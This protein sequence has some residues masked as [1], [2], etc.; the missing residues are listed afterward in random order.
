MTRRRDVVGLEAVLAFLC[1]V[2]AIAGLSSG[3][4]EASSGQEQDITVYG[5]SAA[6]LRD[7]IHTM[8]GPVTD[9]QLARWNDKL[10]ICVFGLKPEFAAILVRTLQSAAESTNLKS[11]VDCN[12]PNVLIAA[13]NGH[14]EI[15]K[16]IIE[17]YPDMPFI[18][19][20]IGMIYQTS[21]GISDHLRQ[22]LTEAK[23]VRWYWSTEMTPN[24][25]SS[26]GFFIQ[27]DHGVVMQPHVDQSDISA[28]RE[29]SHRETHL[30]IVTINTDLA[31]GVSWGALGSYV[32]MVALT[33]PPM[34]AS[35]P[36]YS[37]MSLFE[38]KIASKP[39]RLTEFD[40]RF[41]KAFYASEND[42]SAS[43]QVDEIFRDMT[44][45]RP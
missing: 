4:A 45:G 5:V 40:T 30:A 41:L 12:D 39:D 43:D 28:L 14:T 23:A 15:M 1:A 35:Y 3:V 10:R 2:M 18:N 26:I 29:S 16:S 21:N 11:S 24:S 22:K 37:I 44:R 33:D 31:Q 34:D 7:F 42:V 36:A 17:K 19:N 6:R 8:T 25:D 38:V 32:A 9:R 20:Y 27:T 13:G